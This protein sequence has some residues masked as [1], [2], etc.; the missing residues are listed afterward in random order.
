MM[1]SLSAREEGIEV[2]FADGCSGLVPFADPPEVG[3]LANLPDVELPNPYEAALRTARGDTSELPWDFPRHHCDPSYR[4]RVASIAA[5]GRHTRGRRL[6]QLRE[7]VGMTQ[8]QVAPRA[9]VA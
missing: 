2:T 8:E 4:P 9:S 6:R 3:S 7:A 5:A 1:T